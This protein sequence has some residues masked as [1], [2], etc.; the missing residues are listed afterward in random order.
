MRLYIHGGPYDAE[1]KLSSRFGDQ[2]PEEVIRAVVEDV[3]SEGVYEWA[4]VHT[5]PDYD[6]DF[7]FKTSARGDPYQ[8]FKSRLKEVDALLTGAM[9]DPL[10]HAECRP[11]GVRSALQRP[12]ARNARNPL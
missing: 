3:E 11:I 6:A 8:F 4:P 1:E 10:D 5:E 9:P 2:F 7:E 12:A